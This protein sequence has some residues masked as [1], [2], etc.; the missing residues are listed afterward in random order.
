MVSE[1]VANPILN[2]DMMGVSSFHSKRF[3][4]KT[5]LMIELMVFS[6]VHACQ[7]RTTR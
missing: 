3:K 4:H 6:L 7:S 1:T 5:L 2:R